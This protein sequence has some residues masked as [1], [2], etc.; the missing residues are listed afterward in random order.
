MEVT[1]SSG[2]KSIG[3]LEV[4]GSTLETEE[5]HGVH[6]REG[7]CCLFRAK[8]LES[9]SE[10]HHYSESEMKRMRTMESIDYLPQNSYVYRQWL[11]NEGKPSGA[12]TWGMYALVGFSIG[13]LGFVVKNLIFILTQ[14]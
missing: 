4:D 5:A 9:V 10:H 12:F 2:R 6:N 3:S 14:V 11:R 7:R 1:P 13:I 8:E